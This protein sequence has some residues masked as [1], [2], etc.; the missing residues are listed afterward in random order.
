VIVRRLTILDLMPVVDLYVLSLTH[1]QP[2]EVAYPTFGPDDRHEIAAML[3]HQFTSDPHWWAFGACEADLLCG[4]MVAHLEH[5]PLGYPKR[6][7]MGDAV[8]VHPEWRQENIGRTLI[9]HAVAEGWA[10][11]AEV[12][13]AAWAPHS[14]GAT[15]WP[16]YGMVPYRILGAWAYPDGTPR[17]GLPMQG[18]PV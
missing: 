9:Q 7:V 14:V 2:E 8:V 4:V 16:R 10:R 12:F 15:I 6:V 18:D 11:G 1:L 3:A 13:E 5:R 17:M